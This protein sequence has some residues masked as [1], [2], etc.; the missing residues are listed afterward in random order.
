MLKFTRP[1]DI[2]LTSIF[3]LFE[4]IRIWNLT[5]IYPVEIIHKIIFNITLTWYPCI[6]K[7][8][9]KCFERLNWEL[10]LNNTTY[11]CDFCHGRYY[12]PLSLC[13][14]CKKSYCTHC[15][16]KE[17]GTNPDGKRYIRLLPLCK[18][19]CFEKNKVK[20]ELCNGYTLDLYECDLCK[21][22]VCNKCY[23]ED[24]ISENHEGYKC[25]YCNV[26]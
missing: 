8:S 5:E 26:D 15:D 14:I 12:Y 19:C 17:I 3:S 13:E 22:N 4:F 9:K 6:G 23:N 2:I 16:S 7:E 21:K 24:S 18:D 11:H 20:C 25:D 1:K 10:N